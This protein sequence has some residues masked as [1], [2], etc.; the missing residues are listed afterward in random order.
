M[1]QPPPLVFNVVSNSG[2]VGVFNAPV[3]IARPPLTWPHLVGPVPQLADCYQRRDRTDDI[4]AAMTNSDVRC[5]I[6][7][8][9]GGVGK[10]QLAARLAH[11]AWDRREVDLLIWVNAVSRVSIVEKYAEAA[12]DILGEPAP[13]SETAAAQMLS[14]LAKARDRRW[15]VLLDDLADPNDLDGLWPP[16]C[17]HG[18]SLV[19][20]RRRDPA[21]VGHTRRRLVDVGLFTAGE[22]RRYLR[23]KLRGEHPQAD[24]LAADL[25]HLPLALAQAAAFILE[26]DTDC[27]AY[28][29]L[30]HDRRSRLR[31]LAPDSLP[32]AHRDTVA[33][34]WS[35]S[36]QLAD[37]L[38]PSGLARPLLHLASVLAGNAIPAA[39]FTT[40]AARMYLGTFRT[41]PA[42]DST[43]GPIDE[44]AAR[45]ALQCPRRLNLLDVDRDAGIVRIHG[46]VQRATRDALSA[47]QLDLAV[48]ASVGALVMA[49]PEIEPPGTAQMFRSNATALDVH[50]DD[51]LWS[52]RGYLLHF[53]LGE[54]LMKSGLLGPAL[55]HW[56]RVVTAAT[57]MLGRDHPDTLRARSSAYGCLLDMGRLD[58]A[59]AAYELLLEDL[60]RVLGHEHMLTLGVRGSLAAAKGSA[61][62]PVGALATFEQIHADF[63]RLLGPD[64]PETLTAHAMEGYWRG[65][66]GDPEG[67]A[68]A[69]GTVAADRSRTLG[70]DHPDT[71]VAHANQA[72]WRGMAGDATGAARLF[73]ELTPKLE[74]LLGPEH[75][76]TLS[77]RQSVAYWH[78]MAGNAGA[79]A[80]SYRGILDDYL[81]ILGVDH[82]HTLTT[83]STLAYWLAQDGEF[84]EA[85]R[86]QH[87]ASNETRRLLGADHPDTLRDLVR[88]A[89]RRGEAGDAPGAAEDCDR[90]VPELVR[91]L[92][93]D[94]PDT[95]T[96]RANLGFWRFNAGD[97]SGAVAAFARVLA[98]RSRILGPLHIDTLMTR[99]QLAQA[100]ASN[101]D[102]R[103][104]QAEC[105]N[106]LPDCVTTLGPAHHL[107]LT[108][109]RGLASLRD[110]LGD[111]LGASTDFVDLAADY[112]R[113]LG[114]DSY[115]TLDIRYRHVLALRHAGQQR[116][117]IRALADLH[118]D[119][120]RVLGT[121]HFLTQRVDG[122]L[123]ELR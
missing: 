36:V 55:R 113:V 74:R 81:R 108:V 104:S 114:T 60:V 23:E 10:T 76:D 34:T 11:D 89:F 37:R 71:I 5:Q 118:T 51:S 18:R 83:R 95:L 16:E 54:S 88:L 122:D 103:D 53:H 82:P 22:S 1:D 48:R 31:D 58:E 17:P 119:A 79:A 87:D 32:D 78:G 77:A 63:R 72:R 6:L 50:A 19:T 61:G 80:A 46:L 21:L 29:R 62:D 40:A 38:T 14:W 35:L 112:A 111:P 59:I 107:T 69:L 123:R 30:F 110:R 92:G 33:A 57:A 90:L 75:P 3:T 28:R 68:A 99:F 13:N 65:E 45:S 102:L 39:V 47:E 7:S 8:G 98:E 27:A 49:W 109:R 64:D 67:A 25:G 85:Y 12:G 100:R 106:L 43:P 15:L 117:A 97:A 26:Q 73:D 101:G 44:S 66:A 120:S 116:A 24:N 9:L 94:H 84:D 2:A 52:W 93:N 121:D 42:Q 91:V 86:I 4:H 20:T 70:S 96:I 115:E 56:Q 41:P 105:C